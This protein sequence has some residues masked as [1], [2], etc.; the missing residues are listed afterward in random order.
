MAEESTAANKCDHL[1]KLSKKRV[2]CEYPSP[3]AGRWHA[4]Y[5]AEFAKEHDLPLENVSTELSAGVDY[6]EMETFPL[7]E[8]MLCLTNML[9]KKPHDIALYDG[10]G[11]L[12]DFMKERQMLRLIDIQEHR[13]KQKAIPTFNMASRDFVYDKSGFRQSTM[14]MYAED[15]LPGYDY[16]SANYQCM[17]ISIEAK[18]GDTDFPDGFAF[19][20]N[21]ASV[22]GRYEMKHKIYTAP[23][24][25]KGMDF[26]KAHSFIPIPGVLLSEIFRDLL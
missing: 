22:W 21:K 6:M 8:Q 4:V 5:T 1:P 20:V 25:P 3:P 19:W 2:K 16:F 17:K 15:V 14:A 12:T 23:D 7:E 13:Y 10:P 9:V 24:T 18:R 26:Y 11:T